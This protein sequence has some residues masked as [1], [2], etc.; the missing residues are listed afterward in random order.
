MI[1]DSYSLCEMKGQRNAYSL[2]ECEAL[3][4]GAGAGGRVGFGDE[5]RPELIIQDER[6]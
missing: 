3:L 2:Q 4:L 5:V 1:Q 6:K